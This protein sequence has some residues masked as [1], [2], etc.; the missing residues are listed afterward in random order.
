VWSPYLDC[1]RD[2]SRLRIA[3]TCRHLPTLSIPFVR[4]NLPAL[5]RSGNLQ[6]MAQRHANSMAARRSMDHDGFYSER[7]PRGARAENV[8]YGCATESCAMRMWENSAGHRANMLL[9]DMKAYGLASA[10]G[11]RDRY[12]CLIVG[13]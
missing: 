13:R 4:P 12:W 6:A 3:D 10:S 11:G 5:H 7:G 2:I 1:D 9:T 8:A